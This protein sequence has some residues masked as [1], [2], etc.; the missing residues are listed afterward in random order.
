MVALAEAAEEL[1]E[2][3][4]NNEKNK[5]VLKKDYSLLR[6]F[7]CNDHSD[8]M[9]LYHHKR[10]GEFDCFNANEYTQQLISYYQKNIRV[11]IVVPRT[12]NSNKYFLVCLQN[13]D[14]QQNTLCQLAFQCKRQFLGYAMLMKKKCLICNART[15]MVCTGCRCVCFCSRECQKNGFSNHKKLCKLVKNGGPVQTEEETLDLMKE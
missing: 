11:K 15:D 3:L 7:D 1:E 4:A 13:V 14:M 8:M 2:V 9:V 5:K 10:D 6:E 12:I